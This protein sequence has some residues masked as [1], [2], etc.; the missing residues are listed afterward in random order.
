MSKRIVA[1]V[2]EYQQGNET[3]GKYVRIGTILENNNGE[4]VLLDPS[5][6]LAG[7]AVQQNILNQQ[8]GK[9]AKDNII[10]SVSTD[11]NQ[12]S[13]FQSGNAQGQQAQQG[14]AQSF[15]DFSDSIPF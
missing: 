9:E 1:K 3:K 13:G 14:Q 8:K 10:A 4:Y 5:V 11:Q 6:N 2:G 12:N 15:D 7:V